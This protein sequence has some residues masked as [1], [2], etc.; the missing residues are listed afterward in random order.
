[1]S[2]AFHAQK[3]GDEIAAEKKEDCDPKQSGNHMREAGMTEK[4]DHDGH[5]THA[6]ER[7]DVKRALGG[8]I[9]SHDLE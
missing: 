1:M 2:F 4:H 8:C 5:C 7:S 9:R 3:G 6:I